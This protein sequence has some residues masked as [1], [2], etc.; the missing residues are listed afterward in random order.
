MKRAEHSTSIR[1]RQQTELEHRLD[2]AAG[3]LLSTRH[4]LGVV[5]ARYEEG[6]VI[7]LAEALTVVSGTPVHE[8]VR[9]A[10]D[11]AKGS[12]TIGPVPLSGRG[13]FRNR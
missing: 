12:R 1:S 13:S 10:L 3:R 5:A 9:H 11:G 2:R 7:G 4:Q 6:V 8:V